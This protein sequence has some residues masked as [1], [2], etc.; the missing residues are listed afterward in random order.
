VLF[1][2]LVNFIHLAAE[3]DQGSDYRSCTGAEHQIKALVERASY[4]A[5][6]LLQ[7]AERVEPLRPA[8]SRLRIRHKSSFG[9]LAVRVDGFFVSG[10]ETVILIRLQ[11]TL[12]QRQQ[13]VV[14][15]VIRMSSQEWRFPGADNPDICTL[16]AAR[17]DNEEAVGPFVDAL[18]DFFARPYPASRRIP[19][20]GNVLVRALG[21]R[22]GDARYLNVCHCI[23]FAKLALECA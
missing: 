4:H 21:M 17:V 9:R 12:V 23:S 7:N 6:N 16:T 22:F 18:D 20:V 19:Q 15:I 5:L 2:E 1:V 11:W 3:R 13:V 10:G 8:P 14:P